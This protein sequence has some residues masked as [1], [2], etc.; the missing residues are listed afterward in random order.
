MAGQRWCPVRASECLDHVWLALMRL[1]HLADVHLDRPFVGLPIDDARARRREL[2]A[3][4]ERCLALARERGADLITVGGD[5]WEHEHVTPDTLRWVRDR[6]VATGL[7]VVLVAGNHDPLSPGGPYDRVEFAEQVCV[8][9]A[10]S[11]LGEHRLGD[12]SVGGCLGGR[13]CRYLL[14]R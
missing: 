7:P 1:L 14:R 10:A 2:R 12:L 8:L 3:T 11:A 9:P 5:L 6:L 4:F 13:E